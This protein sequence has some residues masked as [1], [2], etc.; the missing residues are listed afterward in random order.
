MEG[1]INS[2]HSV[3][4]SYHPRLQFRINH[5]FVFARG[6]SGLASREFYNFLDKSWLHDINDEDS[7]LHTIPV[8]IFE[9]SEGVLSMKNWM[10]SETYRENTNVSY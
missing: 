4:Q 5:P 9:L 7:L 2:C 3:R 10:K 6:F 8:M 1:K